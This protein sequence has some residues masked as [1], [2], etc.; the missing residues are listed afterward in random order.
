MARECKASAELPLCVLMLLLLTL[1]GVVGEPSK[2]A[3]PSSLT[4]GLGVANCKS[5]SDCGS[6]PGWQCLSPAA[7]KESV[8]I[9]GDGFEVTGTGKDG[10]TCQAA[11][12]K[13]MTLAIIAG[14][15]IVALI[16][17]FAV[18]TFLWWKGLY[19]FAPVS[20]RR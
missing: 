11:G 13:S 12:S 7:G 10:R 2:T 1:A 16:L 9:C 8:C 4:S 5:P 6:G 18:V 15:L 20:Q 19:C 14:C 3:L 17:T